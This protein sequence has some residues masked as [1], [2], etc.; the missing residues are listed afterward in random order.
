MHLRAIACILRESLRTQA[1]TSP[2][3][4]WYPT[5]SLTH[6]C[7]SGIVNKASYFTPCF[8]GECLGHGKTN[9]VICKC[10]LAATLTYSM[11]QPSPK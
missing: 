9:D 8:V 11:K 2:P 4:G 6:A 1:T 5:P 10:C 3:C 7:A